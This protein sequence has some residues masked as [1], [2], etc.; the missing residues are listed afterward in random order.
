MCINLSIIKCSNEKELICRAYWKLNDEG[1]FEYPLSDIRSTLNLTVSNLASYVRKYSDAESETVKCVNCNAPYLYKSRRDFISHKEELV[2]ECGVCNT[3]D[4]RPFLTN[5][6]LTMANLSHKVFDADNLKNLKITDKVFLMTALIGLSDKGFNCTWSVDCLDNKALTPD[7]I[8]DE[9]IIKR[10]LYL[11]LLNLPGNLSTLCNELVELDDFLLHLKAENLE[12][13]LPP[14]V[15]SKFLKDVDASSLKQQIVE[16]DDFLMLCKDVCLFECISFLL[17]QLNSHGFHFVPGEKTTI[18][19]LKCL[20]DYSVGEVY[21][22]IWKSVLNS[23]SY[24]LK[25]NISRKHAANA[26]IGNIERQYERAIANEWEINGFRRN[27]HLPQS[28][29]SR[30]IFN[31]ILG[32]DDGCF[33]QKLSDLIPH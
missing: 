14:I 16:D 33:K 7:A 1:K 21:L 6:A 32:T 9:A 24:Y 23:S 30:V 31:Q 3:N 13:S 15:L 20:E 17:L 2:W 27:Y 26:V 28:V 8:L 4:S 18:V 10:L 12:F 11:G 22:F 19:L 25:E 5:Q 29:L